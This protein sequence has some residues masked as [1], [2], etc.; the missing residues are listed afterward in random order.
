MKA[1]NLSP[2]TRVHVYAEPIRIN[3]MMDRLSEI[4]A[5]QYKQK[6]RSGD[7]FLFVNKRHDYVKAL[8][9]SSR[10]MCI[11]AK[12]ADPGCKFEPLVT[13]A[14]TGAQLSK[15]L[16]AIIDTRRTKLAR[17]A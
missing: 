13:G 8:F 11:L 6:P 5:K 7:I 2:K 14:I 1:V 10:G 9:Y 4:V 15:L 17:A 12:R 16:S 3:A